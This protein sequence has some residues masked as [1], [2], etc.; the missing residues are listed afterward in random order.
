[1][2]D[3]VNKLTEKIPQNN[4]ELNAEQLS[5]LEIAQRKADVKEL[6]Q[7]Y[8]NLPGMWLDMLWNWWKKTDDVEIQKII[9]SKEWEQSP[10]HEYSTGGLVKNS[11]M[12]EN[13]M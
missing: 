5:T 1:M 13:K 4:Y 7:L 3:D 8:P 9:D 12:V 6:Q 11:V 2:V 10:K